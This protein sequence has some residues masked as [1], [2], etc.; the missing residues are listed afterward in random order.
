MC[1]SVVFLRQSQQEKQNPKNFGMVEK[2]E[3]GVTECGVTESRS[4]ESRSTESRSHGVRSHGVQSHGVRSHG[5]RSHGVRS[6]EY[7]VKTE[8]R[9]RSLSVKC[10]PRR[11][12]DF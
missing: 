9:V 10:S 4:T 3:C 11:G 2:T 6:T 12:G 5:V 7:G 1:T 8:Y